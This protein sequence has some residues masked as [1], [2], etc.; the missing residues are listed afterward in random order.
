MFRP[1]RH[2]RSSSRLPPQRPSQWPATRSVPFLPHKVMQPRRC[3][4]VNNNKNKWNKYN[5]KYN[6]KYLQNNF[7]NDNNKKQERQ[8]ELNNSKQQEQVHM[9]RQKTLGQKSHNL[10]AAEVLRPP[11][12][13]A[14]L[15]SEPKDL[16]I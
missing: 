9:L 11:L 1:C 6:K 7:K 14:F 13:C 8:E 12:D 3:H 4:G 15:V 2:L 16:P 5:K 10:N